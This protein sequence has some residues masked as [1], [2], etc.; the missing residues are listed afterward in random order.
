MAEFVSTSIPPQLSPGKHFAKRLLFRPRDQW[1]I[2]FLVVVFACLLGGR[3]LWQ[4]L[5][6]NSTVSW[7]APQSKPDISIRVDINQADWPELALLPQ[8]GE[9][10]AKRIVEDRQKRGPFM[11]PQDLA[12]VKGIGPKTLAD[13]LPYLSPLEE[14][15]R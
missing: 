1:G 3:L 5:A 6:G 15:A 4:R 11:A 10:L 8:I 7:D 9:A 12:R 14:E 13:L 2:G